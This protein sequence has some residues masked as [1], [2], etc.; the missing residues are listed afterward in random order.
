MNIGDLEI[1]GNIF[2]APMCNVTSLPFRLL[3]K[4]Y[5]AAMMYSEMIHADAYIRD[6]EKSAKRAYFLEEERPIGIQLTGS[7][8]DI[9][10][11]AIKK[12]EK[13]LHPD[14]VDINIGC[15][16]YNVIKSGAGSALL[17]DSAKLSALVKRLSSA[18]KIPLTCKIRILPYEEDTIKIAKIIEKSGA[19]AITVH[20]RTVKQK[21]SGKADWE[22]I[23]K[24]K[25]TISIPVILNGDIR[26]EESAERAFENTGCDAV[27]I[28]R[29]VIGNPFLF[30][31]IN[32]YLQTGEKL[33][34]MAIKERAE[35]FSE[36][37][38][39]CR[40]YGY[41]NIAY[42]KMEATNFAKKFTGAA[43]IRE[44][45]SKCSNAED[46]ER[47]LRSL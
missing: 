24:V 19:K 18:I 1:K 8:I 3:C 45:I 6:N 34:E 35:E 12:I 2:L 44:G 10:E 15:P 40:K 26:D 30:R 11:R 36:F 9:L 23:R 7:D 29:A 31:R 22:I 5:G 39:L 27:M 42:I 14:L 28:G 17:K 46:I 43:K 32:H 33:P 47:I 16:A 37:I 4:K 38:G 25:E 21:Y 13:E 20:G 41:T